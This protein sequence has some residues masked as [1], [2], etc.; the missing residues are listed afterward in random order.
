MKTALYI[1]YGH[2][3]LSA[4]WSLRQ[5]MG[6]YLFMTKILLSSNE[7]FYVSSKSPA[8][9]EWT[10]SEALQSAKMLFLFVGW[11]F[12]PWNFWLIVLTKVWKLAKRML[13]KLKHC[14]AGV[15]WLTKLSNPA[16]RSIAGTRTYQD[17]WIS[18][19]WRFHVPLIFG[20]IYMIIFYCYVAVGCLWYC[21]FLLADR[22]TWYLYL[23]LPCLYI[24][25]TTQ[26]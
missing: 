1:K 10:L 19:C 24:E 8:G 7:A 22:L 20:C 9:L 4:P 15:S 16:Q 25:V 17:V 2:N 11:Y 13:L 12:K 3:H 14:F 6:S 5:L 26:N 21:N 23:G 18:W